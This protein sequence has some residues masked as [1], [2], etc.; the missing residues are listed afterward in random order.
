MTNASVVEEREVG[1]DYSAEAELFPA[2]NRKSTNWVQTFC[3]RCGR[4]PF[5]NRGA[6]V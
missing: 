3:A 2:R 6:S 1:F 5:R 4:G